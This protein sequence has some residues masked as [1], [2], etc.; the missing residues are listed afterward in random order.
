MRKGVYNHVEFNVQ[1]FY[2]VGSIEGWLISQEIGAK[3][4]ERKVE[5]YINRR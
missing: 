4:V 3:S 1:K 5:R 2:P